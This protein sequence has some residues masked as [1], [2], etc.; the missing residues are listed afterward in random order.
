[1]P[2]SAS[3][4]ATATALDALR[5]EMRAAAIHE[6]GHVV[7][8]L[9]LGF[10]VGS[11]ELTISRT[12]TGLRVSTATD[13]GLPIPTETLEQ[14]AAAAYEPAMLRRR[15][16][17]ALAGVVAETMFAGPQ[18]D[19]ARS[20]RQVRTSTARITQDLAL[21]AHFVRTAAGDGDEDAAFDACFAECQELLRGRADAVVRIAN[22]LMRC[23]N[24]RLPREVLRL[25]AAS[26]A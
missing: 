9:A 17:Q 13:V 6:A 21:V 8:A 5:E 19:A 11:A 24:K 22:E 16:V 7:A 2:R 12:R 23:A 3:H 26:A 15:T 10:E 4:P 20:T 25:D 1:M 18:R 14:S